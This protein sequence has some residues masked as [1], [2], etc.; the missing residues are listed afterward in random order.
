MGGAEKAKGGRI[1]R[2]PEEICDPAGDY[3][4]EVSELVSRGSADVLS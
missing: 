3:R 4:R 1:V 2:P